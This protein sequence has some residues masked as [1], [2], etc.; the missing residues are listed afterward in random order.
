MPLIVIEGLD[1]SGKSTQTEL[2]G[3]YLDR[4][5][6]RWEHLHFPR[7]DTPVYGKLIARFLRGELGD[8]ASVD[9]YIVAMMFA[10]DRAGAAARLR[11]WL[12]EGTYVLLDRYVESN[13]AYQCAKLDSAPARDELRQWIFEL[14]YGLNAIPEPD[15]SLLLDVPFRFTEQN[16]ISRR[17]NEGREYL[18]GADDI[19]ESSLAFQRRVRDMYM[20]AAAEGRITTVTC[21]D[22]AG[23]MLQPQQ[24]A[25]KIAT[26]VERIMK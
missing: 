11:S 3:R 26:E 16:L 20:L 8:I 6:L 18:A 25:A 5:G 9:P 24:V 1:G 4:R 17:A 13:I 14:E 10:G 15:L 21:Y 12:A 23:S 19:H 7:F 22:A 2:L